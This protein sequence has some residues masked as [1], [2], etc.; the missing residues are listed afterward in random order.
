M[1]NVINP[2]IGKPFKKLMAVIS[3]YATFNLLC[4]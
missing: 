3:S 1:R 2:K 4:R